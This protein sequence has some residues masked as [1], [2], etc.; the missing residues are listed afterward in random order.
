MDNNNKL[1]EG[2]GS[3]S[4][5]NAPQGWGDPTK[6]AS[7]AETP[8]TSDTQQESADNNSWLNQFKESEAPVQSQANVDSM[9]SEPA[10]EISTEQIQQAETVSAPRKPKV[11]LIAV[12]VALVVLIPAGIFGGM[13]LLG[14]DDGESETDTPV[15]TSDDATTMPEITTETTTTEESVAEIDEIERMGQLYYDWLISQGQITV[16]GGE[17]I[18][19]GSNSFDVNELVY[20]VGDF[21]GD[22][23]LD[24]AI[25]DGYDNGV[26]IYTYKNESVEPLFTFGMPY[27]AGAEV[28]VL[29]IYENEYGILTFRESSILSFT[30]WEIDKN[31]ESESVL[32]GSFNNFGE[33][34]ISTDKEVFDSITR[35]AFYAID[36]LG[37]NETP[38]TT[39]P[40][41][42]TTTQQPTTTTQQPTPPPQPNDFVYLSQYPFIPDILS[43]SS[44]FRLENSGTPTSGNFLERRFE[45]VYNYSCFNYDLYDTELAKYRT[46]LESSGFVFQGDNSN[47]EFEGAYFYNS[48]RDISL[49]HLAGYTFDSQLVIAIGRGN[50]YSMMP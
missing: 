46:A 18:G 47:Y 28:C 10:I 24:L 6:A 30:F 50:V 4:G 31:G 25:S 44:N 43:I 26:I 42:Q 37:R 1:P 20:Y 11:G 5:S 16:E 17:M 12:I 34:D 3:T 39:T 9:Q 13:Y 19:G 40:P 15:V 7:F 33:E 21:N 14:G 22:G 38:S 41:P 48:E 32:S 27:S 23:I 8:T 35:V 29:A 49:Y 45:F 2:W 36:S